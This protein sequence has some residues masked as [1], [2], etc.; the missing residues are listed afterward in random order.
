MSK[1]FKPGVWNAVCGRCG[2]EFKSN[3]L[4]EL[5]E[6]PGVYVC[7]K[8]W[9]P[10]HI[11]DFFKP[12]VDRGQ[13]VPWSQDDSDVV[14]GRVVVTAAMSPYDV[15]TTAREVSIDASGGAITLTLP[16]ATSVP[17]IGS[18]ISFART[19][20]TANTVI[21]ARNG[22][23]LVENGLFITLNVPIGIRLRSDAVKYWRYT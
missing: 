22:S 11:L 8:D 21:I 12:R 4:K 1:Y 5:P 16:L 10:R 3:E 14:V 6:Y 9:E 18:F 7:E 15:P 23:D 13:S 17:G 2:F 19:D 20:S